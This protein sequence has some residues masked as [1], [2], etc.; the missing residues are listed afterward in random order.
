MFTVVAYIECDT[1]E[2]AMD[3]ALTLEGDYD[4]WCDCLIFHPGEELPI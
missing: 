1:H 3:I 4:E 2:E